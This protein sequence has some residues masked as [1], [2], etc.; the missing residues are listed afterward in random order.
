MKHHKQKEKEKAGTKGWQVEPSDQ[1]KRLV[2][3]LH[4]R[5]T[6]VT[7]ARQMKRLLEQNRCQV[8]GHIE[9][10]ASRLLQV[11][12]RV[13]FTIETDAQAEGSQ[14][15][16]SAPPGAQGTVSGDSQ[17]AHRAPWKVIH[18]DQDLIVANKPPGIAID[19]EEG[20]AVLLK[21]FG[22][23]FLV[24]R[25]DKETSGLLLLART[26]EM[27]K[28]LE[29]LFRTQDIEKGYLAL[30]D[31]LI[32]EPS[33]EIRNHIGKVRAYE[34]Q[35]L[36]GAVSPEHGRLAHTLW[37]VLACGQGAT[38]VACEPKT[39]RTHQIRVHMKSMGH[40]ILGDYQYAR[41]FHCALR[42]ARCLLHAAELTFTHPT[43]GERKRYRAKLPDDFL[44][45]L[46][47]LRVPF[48]RKAQLRERQ[49]S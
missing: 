7:S 45:A 21:E 40:P 6:Q 15:P 34:G 10:F 35:A 12:D 16:R 20:K 29:A 24:H 49:K 37:R 36:R 44:K 13:T 46:H 18:Q 33:G 1:G 25:L 48:A 32:H 30:V 8:N 47:T 38:L 4:E 23:I 27:G 22:N 2:L 3:F 28:S 5:V 31:G 14:S 17:V 39:G 19:T 11:G 43:T 42:P 9:R 26:K 41:S